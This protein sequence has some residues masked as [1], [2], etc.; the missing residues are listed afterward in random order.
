MLF[1]N[2]LL[3]CVY[4]FFPYVNEALVVFSHLTEEDP[5]VANTRQ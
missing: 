1:T 5:Q 3:K 2:N 4:Y